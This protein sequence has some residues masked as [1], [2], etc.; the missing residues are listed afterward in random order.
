M[1]EDCRRGV[2]NLEKD[3]E[4]SRVSLLGS[5]EM[6]ELGCITEGG[7]RSIDDP[8]D[9]PDA[10]LPWGAS[11]TIASVATALARHDSGILQDDENGLEELLGYCAVL[12]E[13]VDLD[14]PGI[15][16]LGQVDQ[17]FER[18]E[19]S[20]RNPQAENLLELSP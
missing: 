4:E 5:D 19:P 6:S 8:N 14:E 12:G 1:V 15:P 18:V 10:Y 16:G 7:E 9:L 2:A 11:Q 13:G 3:L 20:L 17:G